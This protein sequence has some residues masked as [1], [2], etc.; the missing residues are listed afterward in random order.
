MAQNNMKGVGGI[1]NTSFAS[2]Y[3]T[4]GV[5]GGAQRATGVTLQVTNTDT[6]QR[7]VTVKILDA[8]NSLNPFVIANLLPIPANG[9]INL[10]TGATFFEAADD[11]QIMA[12]A[13]AKVNFWLSYLEKV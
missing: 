8:S 2:I 11:L 3:K 1:C 13:A 5:A 6:V 9:T 4:P 7:L 10:L 12:D